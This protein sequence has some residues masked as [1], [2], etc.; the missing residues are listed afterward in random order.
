MDLLGMLAKDCPQAE[1]NLGKSKLY[2][3]VFPHLEQ[4]YFIH[5]LLLIYTRNSKI[6]FG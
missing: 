5:L 4:K 3:V 2:A 1:Q 6:S